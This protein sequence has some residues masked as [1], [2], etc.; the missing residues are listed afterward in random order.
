MKLIKCKTTHNDIV[1]INIEKITAFETSV[2]SGHIKI[3]INDKRYIVIYTEEIEKLI[4]E[5]LLNN[6]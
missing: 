3:Y 6:E 5:N 4:K 2:F 1:W